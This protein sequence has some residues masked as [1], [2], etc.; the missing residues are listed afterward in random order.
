MSQKIDRNNIKLL[1]PKKIEWFRK[2]LL[3]W[4]KQ[5]L[6]EFP[7]R[8]TKDA[9]SILVAECLLQKT[10]AETVAPVYQKFLAKYPTVSDLAKGNIEEIASILQSLGLLF[11]ASRLSDSAKTII[12]RYCGNVPNSES[13]LLELSGIGI[14][15]A[16]AICSQAFDRPLAV[17][18]ANVARIL[19]RFFGIQGERVKSR[20]KILWQAAEIIAPE[21]QV[22]Q[23]NLTLL[24]F[25]ALIC[26]A[27]NP[28]C[29]RCCLANKCHWLHS[30][31]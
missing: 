2:Q 14:Y 17:L 20:C 5:N 24:D 15:T 18:D 29:D 25:G 22:G 6:R 16:R 26:T 30:P 21:N 1:R 28:A 13:Q 9:Y 27:R 23:W 11:R 31:N 19:E 4:G 12:D 10:D 7:W 8:Q 3:D